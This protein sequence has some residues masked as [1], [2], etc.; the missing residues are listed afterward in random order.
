MAAAGQSVRLTR[1]LGALLSLKV[2]T[3]SL[4]LLSLGRRASPAI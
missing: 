3:V 2:H 4:S 1:A